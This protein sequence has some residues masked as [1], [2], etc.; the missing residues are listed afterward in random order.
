[1]NDS[2]TVEMVQFK[3]VEGAREEDFLEAADAMMPDLERQS[4][5]TRRELL[6]GEDGQW[7]DIVHCKSLA[8]AQRAAENVLGIPSC[9]QFFGMID[10]T[11]MVMTHFEQVKA[12]G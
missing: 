3:L 5:F 7:M 6:R 9:Q 11:T 12:Y 1:M 8:E 2:L 4:G 10:L